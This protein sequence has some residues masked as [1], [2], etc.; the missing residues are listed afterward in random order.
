MELNHEILSD[1]VVWS[2][3]AKYDDKKQRRE[4]WEEAVGR[5]FD[6][7]RKKYA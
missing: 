4:T 5:V 2:K 3:Y 1:I 7:H 6:M